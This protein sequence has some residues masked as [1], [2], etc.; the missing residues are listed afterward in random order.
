MNPESAIGSQNK[1]RSTDK[2]KETSSAYYLDNREEIEK[3]KKLYYEANRASIYLK[4]RSW[5]LSHPEKTKKYKKKYKHK[6]ESK[7]KAR[8]WKRMSYWLKPEVYREKARRWAREHL[9]YGRIR[10]QIRLSRFRNVVND[11]SVEDWENT[12]EVFGGMCVYCTSSENLCMDHF[13]PL[14]KGGP[15]TKKNI[16][17]ACKSCNSSKNDSDP[18]DWV[19]RKFGPEVYEWIVEC[20]NAA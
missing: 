16:V 20:L 12:L 4:N 7:D 10:Q 2:Y 9:E 8:I 17:P 6:P 1:Y 5:F 15:T 11:Y 3:Y 13:V 19:I 14:A 18:R